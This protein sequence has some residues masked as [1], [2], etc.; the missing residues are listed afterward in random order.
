MLVL[1]NK[2][3]LVVFWKF[4]SDDDHLGLEEHVG[5]RVAEPGDSIQFVDPCEAV[6]VPFIPTIGLVRLWSRYPIRNW[7]IRRDA[8][9]GSG[10]DGPSSLVSRRLLNE[11]LARNALAM[12]KNAPVVDL[13]SYI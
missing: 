8:G 6:E 12:W 7:S 13:Y 9:Q 4:G 3:V 11:G 10:G 2:E 1:S 5:K